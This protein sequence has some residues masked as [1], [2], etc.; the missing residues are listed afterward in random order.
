MSRFTTVIIHDV[1]LIKSTPRA[2]L[3]RDDEGNEFWIP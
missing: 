2:G 3:Y 1:T